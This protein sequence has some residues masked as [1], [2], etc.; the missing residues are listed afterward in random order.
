MFRLIVYMLCTHD[1]SFVN[2]SR[3][4]SLCYKIY[5]YIYVSRERLG[6]YHYQIEF[7]IIKHYFR[8]FIF[9]RMMEEVDNIIIHSL[10]Q[11]GW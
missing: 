2:V 10:R 5:I 3:H 8:I 1:I 4:L 11:I 6:F 7:C 9:L